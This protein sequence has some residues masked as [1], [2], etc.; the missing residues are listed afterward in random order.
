MDEL[1]VEKQMQDQNEDGIMSDNDESERRKAIKRCVQHK[2][3]LINLND[4]ILN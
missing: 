3:S 2:Y 1:L 4:Y